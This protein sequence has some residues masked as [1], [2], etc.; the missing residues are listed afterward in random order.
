MNRGENKTKKINMK[1]KKNPNDMDF[2]FIT[3]ETRRQHPLS[4]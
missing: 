1:R 4:R 3:T 2:V